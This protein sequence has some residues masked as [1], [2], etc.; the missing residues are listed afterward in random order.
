MISLLARLLPP[1][2]IPT[3]IALCAALVL[4]TVNIFEYGFGYLPCH[5]CLYQRLPWWIALGLSSVAIM[6]LKRRGVL[7]LLISIVALFAIF[8]GAGL[9]AY[10]AGV[11]YQFWAGPS[12]CTGAQELSSGLA[13][14][15]QNIQTGPPAPSCDAAAWTLFGISM[16]GYNFL[17]SLF[18]VTIGGM[19]IWKGLDRR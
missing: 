2:R 6:L 16:A 4:I 19:A 8:I 13:G 11:E 12:G 15:I 9:A 7:S 3:A 10:H 1:Q 17:F 18:V 14:A 5:L